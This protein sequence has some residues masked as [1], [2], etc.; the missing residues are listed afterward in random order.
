M[1]LFAIAVAM[2][3]FCILHAFDVS[4]RNLHSIV[5][6]CRRSQDCCA[7]L[8]PETPR[9]SVGSFNCNVD[10]FGQAIFGFYCYDYSGHGIQKD[11]PYRAKCGK[12]Q[13]AW[14]HKGPEDMSLAPFEDNFRGVCIYR[15]TVREIFGRGRSERVCLR[16]LWEWTHDLHLSNLGNDFWEDS[17]YANYWESLE[18]SRPASSS[19]RYTDQEILYRIS[20]W[21]TWSDGRPYEPA[22]LE[23]AALDGSQKYERQSH[24][25]R[26]D[27]VT[28]RLKTDFKACTASYED[29]L[30]LILNLEVSPLAAQRDD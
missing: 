5:D 22:F 29:T 25:T 12:N 6:R 20:A 3:Y 7:L 23:L 24:T 30:D 16:M 2:I 10:L 1:R 11:G 21:T 18:P 28:G 15:R 17:G 4:R 9:R 26:I 13:V 27:W 14:C 19:Q 8:H